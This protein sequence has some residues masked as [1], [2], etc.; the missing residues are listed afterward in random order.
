RV[1]PWFRPEAH[2]ERGL[3]AG[4]AWIRRAQTDHAIRAAGHRGRPAP[5]ASIAPAARDMSAVPP[6]G[7]PWETRLPRRWFH[8]RPTH[9]P[10]PRSC[11]QTRLGQRATT[12][13]GRALRLLAS[14]LARGRAASPVGPP[15][16]Q[17]WS[18]RLAWP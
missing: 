7:H 1:A 16:R 8:Q 14:R 2:G 12:L 15:P 3:P 4:P 18:Q 17:Y 6:A 9:L 10:V 11:W 5:P 13:P